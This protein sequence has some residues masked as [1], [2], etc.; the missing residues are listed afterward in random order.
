MIY[1]VG[2]LLLLGPLVFIHELGHYLAAKLCGVRVEVFSLGFGK[3]IFGFKRGGTD[4]RVSALPLG[5]Y[6]R[7]AGENPMEEHTGDPGEFMSHPRWQRFIIAIAGPAMNVVLAIALL[8]GLYMV[9]HPDQKFLKQ[10]AVVEWVEPN[11]VAAKVGLQ[12]GDRIVRLDSEDTPDWGAFFERASLLGPSPVP[13]YIERGGQRLE[14]QISLTSGQET[15]PL[16]VGPDEPAV[17]DLVEASTPAAAAGIKPGDQLVKVNG[18]AVHLFSQIGEMID[19]FQK[20]KDAPVVLTLKRDN[21][22]FDVKVTPRLTAAGYKIGVRFTHVLSYERLPFAAALSASVDENGKNSFLIVQV[23]ERLVE[24]KVSIKQ[25]SG[26]VGI[27]QISGEALRAGWPV[28]I[29]IMALISLNLGIFNLLPIPIL[30]GGLILLLLIEGVLRRDIKREVK[31][32]V[33][34]AAFVFLVI[35][36]VVVIYNDIQKI[37]VSR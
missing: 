22:V 6:V 19:G 24:R 2:I 10:P 23:L 32:M 20:S 1:V 25:M 14:K 8:S 9:H 7:M 21:Q 17:A 36:A 33:Y 37:V 29:E 16:G 28:F 13:L 5:G 34:Q 11:S 15:A 3:R 12:P 26:P 4:Y 18:T 30:D 27:A 31:E 35:F